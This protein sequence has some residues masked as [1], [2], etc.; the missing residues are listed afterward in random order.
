MNKELLVIY[1][2]KECN[3]EEE[4]KGFD[5]NCISFFKQNDKIKSKKLVNFLASQVINNTTKPK[6][7]LKEKIRTGYMKQLIIADKCYTKIYGKSAIL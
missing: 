4:Y 1:E 6:N 3:Y 7:P 2:E 5:N